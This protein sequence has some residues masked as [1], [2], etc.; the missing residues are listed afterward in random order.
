[1]NKNLEIQARIQEIS[2]V[3][4][5]FLVYAGIFGKELLY[6]MEPWKTQHTHWS[7]FTFGLGRFCSRCCLATVFIRRRGGGH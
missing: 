3:Y 5:H 6:W 2:I 7:Y 4:T 1:M